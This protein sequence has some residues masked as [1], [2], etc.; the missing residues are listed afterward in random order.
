VSVVDGKHTILTCSNCR[1]PLAD[2]W[3]TRPDPDFRWKVKA[4]C[5]FC[6]DSSFEREVVGRFHYS[7]YGLPNEDDEEDSRMATVV[8]RPEWDGDRVTLYTGKGPFADSI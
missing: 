6:G 5:C 3:V 1:K 2:I 8:T 4:A 7:G